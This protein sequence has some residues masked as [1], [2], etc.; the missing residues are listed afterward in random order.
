[1]HN[2]DASGCCIECG[3][4]ERLTA[5]ELFRR[6]R[7]SVPQR[8]VALPVPAWLLRGITPMARFSRAA[9][10]AA[11]LNDDLLADNSRLENVLGVHP[12]GF[13]PEPGAWQEA[14]VKT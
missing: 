14:A 5:S 11:R 3:G 6:V 7:D 1:L 4:G 10:A 2:A 9:S 8:T 12:R 13:D